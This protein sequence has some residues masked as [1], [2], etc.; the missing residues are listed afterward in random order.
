MQHTIIKTLITLP[1]SFNKKYIKTFSLKV[2]LLSKT[3]YSVA[4][5]PTDKI[6]LD[7]P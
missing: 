4:C 1:T 5:M 3:E 6:I 2:K 7:M